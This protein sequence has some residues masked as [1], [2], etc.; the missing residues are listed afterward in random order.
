MAGSAQF[1]SSLFGDIL[2]ADI[3]FSSEL[4]WKETCPKAPIFVSISAAINP[5]NNQLINAN[6]WQS[7]AV[8]TL[9][10]IRCQRRT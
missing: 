8:E 3:G 7:E 6:S 10:T 9:P 1:G 2:F 4:S 5:W